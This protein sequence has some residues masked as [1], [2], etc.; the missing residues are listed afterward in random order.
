MLSLPLK[1]HLTSVQPDTLVASN[2]FF[3][4]PDIGEKSDMHRQSVFHVAVKLQHLPWL[5]YFAL[6]GLK[7]L[8]CLTGILGVLGNEQCRYVKLL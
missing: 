4:E 3:I 2:F 6:C 8:F 1:N 7:I 5:L